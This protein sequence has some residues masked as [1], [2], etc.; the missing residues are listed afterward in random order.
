MKTEGAKR[1][2]GRDSE[3]GQNNRKRKKTAKK[4]VREERGKR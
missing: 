2:K 1:G 3:E 4:H